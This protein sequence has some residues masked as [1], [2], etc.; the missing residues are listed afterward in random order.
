MLRPKY[1]FC[2]PSEYHASPD[3]MDGLPPNLPVIP[4]YVQHKQQG[5]LEKYAL[6]MAQ[7]PIR[8]RMCGFGEKDRRPL[9]PPPVVKLRVRDDNGN[10]LKSEDVDI[11]KFVVSATLWA[12]HSDNDRSIV[13]NPNTLPGSVPMYQSS[14]SVMSLN[15]PVKVRNLVGT[16]VS[17]AYL[18]KDE[19]DELHIFFIFHDLSVRTEGQFRLKFQFTVIPSEDDP[20]AFV[21]SVTWSNVFEVYSAKTFPGMTD[22]TELSKAFATQ[23]IKITIRKNSRGRQYNYNADYQDDD[24]DHYDD[25]NINAAS[26][27]GASTSNIR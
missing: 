19:H 5:Q 24:G 20:R 15:E 14:T 4:T 18:L 9:D 6:E 3:D 23:G 22:S 7:H 26:G 11:W 12:P 21:E 1:E 10:F 27:A 17:N 2:D 25:D 16:T 8:A 13:I